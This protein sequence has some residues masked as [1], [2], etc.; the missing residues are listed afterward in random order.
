[1]RPSTEP[2]ESLISFVTDRP[3]HDWRYAIDSRKIGAA[4]DWKPRETFQSGI[5]KTI[6]WYLSAKADK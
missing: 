6:Q 3:G 4:L 5:E 1:L 2:Y